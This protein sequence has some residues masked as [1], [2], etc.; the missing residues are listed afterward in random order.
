MA[1]KM[2]KALISQNLLIFMLLLL[3]SVCSSVSSHKILKRYG[4]NLFNFELIIVFNNQ[5]NV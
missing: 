4:M 5:S 3:Y 1:L 2:S